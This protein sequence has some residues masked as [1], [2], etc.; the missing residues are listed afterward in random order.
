MDRR[1]P[2]AL[3]LLATLSVLAPGCARERITGVETT[4]LDRKLSTFAWI[5]EG[6]IATL[7]VNTQPARDRDGAPYMPLEIAVANN[8]LRK[9]TLTRESFV[10]VDSEGNRYPLATPAELLEGY[11][12][13]E[14]DRN[15]A[16][17]EGIVFNKF[18]A[19]ARY[20]SNWSPRAAPA[21]T[22]VVID[23]VVLP[24]FGY[25]I[26]FVYFP[27]PVTGIRDRQF[28]LFVESPDLPDPV[29]VKFEVN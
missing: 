3:L 18:A 22:S 6:E 15:L 2:A 7:I 8:G 19:Y 26:D 25:L 13:L 9:L 27:A 14:F 4:A 1:A 28:E 17:L 11:D 29:F 16:E 5:E 21:A 20:P 24:K 10:L 23:L 12:M